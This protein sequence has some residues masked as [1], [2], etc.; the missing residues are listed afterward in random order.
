M[1][2][3]YSE[4]MYLLKNPQIFMEK[5]KD[6]LKSLPALKSTSLYVF[7][8]FS[9]FSF[10]VFILVGK[11]CFLFVWLVCRRVVHTEEGRLLKTFCSRNSRSRSTWSYT[12]PSH[13]CW[14]S[15]CGTTATK[16]T[17]SS[18]T[19]TVAVQESEWRCIFWKE[20]RAWMEMLP[21]PRKL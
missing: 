1:R 13:T 5:L 4:V 10:Y 12:C 2:L 14:R 11:T 19:A 21:C 8:K 18:A 9:F 16:P 7:T 15:W 20:W 6:F 3:N 17:S